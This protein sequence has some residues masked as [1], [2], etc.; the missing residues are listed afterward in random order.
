MEI[1]AVCSTCLI[2]EKIDGI[3][4]VDIER[5]LN[6]QHVQD[7]WPNKTAQERE[8]IMTIRSGTYLCSPCWD[9]LWNEEED[10][11]PGVPQ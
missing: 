2:Q 7:V 5:W 4:E 10:E 8:L 1:K 9:I 3:D 11:P 6:G